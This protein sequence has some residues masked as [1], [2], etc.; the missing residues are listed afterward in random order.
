L[1]LTHDPKEAEWNHEFLTEILLN[2]SALILG[3]NNANL[4]KVIQVLARIYDTKFSNE[5]TDAKIKDIMKNI[6]ENSQLF[7]FVPLALESND[8]KT[9]NKINTLFG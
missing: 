5:A 2:N 8:E 6:K 3:N 1:P 4:P 9:K 7:A